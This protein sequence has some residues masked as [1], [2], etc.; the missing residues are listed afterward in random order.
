[1]N[2]TRGFHKG[3]PCFEY[4]EV[5]KIQFKK[6]IYDYLPFPLRCRRLVSKRM[7][8]V[9]WETERQSKPDFQAFLNHWDFNLFSSVWMVKIPAIFDSLGTV[10]LYNRQDI[11]WRKILL[12]AF[13]HLTDL[14]LIICK[15]NMNK[16]PK[17]TGIKEFLT[18]KKGFSLQRREY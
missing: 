16:K 7:S 15:D 17:K 3:S 2:I 4:S 13:C 1:M 11:F 14:V 10:L 18:V 8:W 9:L 5:S 6:H 12:F